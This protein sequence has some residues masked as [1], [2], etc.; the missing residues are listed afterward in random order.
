[1]SYMS[2][3]RG[4]STSASRWLTMPTTARSRPTKSSTSRTLRGRPTL[5]GTT[6]AGNTTLFRSGSMG[7]SSM[8]PPER[9][10]V[11]THA[12]NAK[13]PT[14]QGSRRGPVALGRPLEPEECRSRP[15][16][17]PVLEEVAIRSVGSAW[18]TLSL[19]LAISAMEIGCGAGQ[20]P[21]GDD[22]QAVL[23]AYA[24]FLEEGRPDEAYRLLS[25]EA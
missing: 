4:S 18:R 20:H 17:F 12:Y 23:H 25:D 10:S 14:A 24:R 11:I 5:M 16:A 1:M 2:S 6:L 13:P 22:P 8:S 15:D 21:G 19:V 7:R 9:E 3:K